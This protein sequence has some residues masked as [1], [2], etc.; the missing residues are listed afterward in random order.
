MAKSESDQSG[1]T[2]ESVGLRPDRLIVLRFD[3]HPKRL[4]QRLSTTMVAV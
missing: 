3:S 1:R 2:Y 4:R